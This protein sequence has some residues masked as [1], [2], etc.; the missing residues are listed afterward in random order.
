M[1]FSPNRQYDLQ[2][3]GTNV[4]TW[5]IVLNSN[6]S[7]ID[8]NLGG[9]L[10]LSVAG[11]SNI[12]LTGAQAQNLIHN[13]TG[14]LTG[15]INYTFPAQGGFFFI[16]NATSGNFTVTAKVAGGS[17]GLVVP[18]GG[19]LSIYIDAN[20]LTVGGSAGTQYIYTG[21][22]STGTST[23]Y[24][25]A[26]PFPT[27]F[28]L[29]NGTLITWT[30]HTASG[31]DATLNVGGSGAKNLQKITPGGLVNI[32]AGDM[33]QTPYICQYN[34]TVWIV[35]NI[36]IEPVVATAS[37]SFTWSFAS[38]FTLY[39]CSA[40]LTIG[41]P[42]SAG[43]PTYTSFGFF[44]R[45]GAVTLLPNGTDQINNGGAGVSLVAPI[46]SSG[47]VM[48]DGAGRWY[49]FFYTGA[50]APLASPTLTGTPSAPTASPGT[51]TTQLATTAFVLANATGAPL[52]SPAF[53][54]N[55]TAPTPSSNDSDTSIATTAF[56]NP[57]NTKA[58]SCYFKLP[59]GHILQMGVTASINSGVTGSTTLPIAFPTA[60]VSVV[61][62]RN[63][64]SALSGSPD[65]AI[66]TSLSAFTTFN[67]SSTAVTFGYVAMGY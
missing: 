36:I 30:P 43:L 18:Q 4:N 1:P 54:G 28:S 22:T 33:A 49:T 29:T 41:L 7:I 48:T 6:F 39:Q 24:V 57:G 12:T 44:A 5:G 40:P 60:A 32:A 56:V 46:G 35:L 3:T 50:Y 15:N 23:A 13:L 9:T 45:G 67:A 53:T 38:L 19:V 55:P 25:I 47:Q 59:S 8:A 63:S 17:G 37:T 66:F 42:V 20:T 16:N 10:N 27:N 62:T 2:A 51:N 34:G 61:V 65:S 14:A 21:G 11:N 26:T 31:A 58:T 64:A 52:N